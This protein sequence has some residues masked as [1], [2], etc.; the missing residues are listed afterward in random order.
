MQFVRALTSAN[1][2]AGDVFNAS[3]VD[4]VKEDYVPSSQACI[5]NFRVEHKSIRPSNI[6]KLMKMK[7]RMRKASSLHGSLLG[8]FK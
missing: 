1:A 5:P 8:N 3:Y 4:Y 7:P 2:N 6:V